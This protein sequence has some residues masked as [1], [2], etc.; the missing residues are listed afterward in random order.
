MKVK[1]WS[2]SDVSF[3]AFYDRADANTLSKLGRML[4]S[5]SQKYDCEAEGSP[6]RW[7]TIFLNFFLE[8]CEIRKIL[9]KS[10]SVE[11]GKA[12]SFE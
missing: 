9:R 2:L 5:K 1:V 6:R 4:S 3:S 12:D 8:G 11:G 10:F 7:Q